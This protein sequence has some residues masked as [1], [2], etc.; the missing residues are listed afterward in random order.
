M[1]D[2]ASHVYTFP[3]FTLN[4]G[5]SVQVWTGSGTNTS[6][7]LYWGSGNAVWNNTGDTATLKDDTGT[8]V[9][10]YTY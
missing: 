7:D 9:D 1:S 4:A 2:L 10:E 5:A 8:L 6:T 3:V